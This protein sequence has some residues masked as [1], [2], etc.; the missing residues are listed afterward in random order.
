MVAVRED[1]YDENDLFDGGEKKRHEKSEVL[2][3][4]DDIPHGE[5]DF[6]HDVP[7]CMHAQIGA[8]Q[9][10]MRDILALESGAIIE[11]DKV[12]GEPM[13]VVIGK[14][15]MCRGEIVVVNERYGIRISEVMRTEDGHKEESSV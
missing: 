13:D 7:I 6:V 4:D 11:F 1:E 2:I 5:V 10:T 3:D 14:R 9:K 15:L 8:V 12:V